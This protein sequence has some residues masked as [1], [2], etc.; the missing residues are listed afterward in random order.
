MVA[1]EDLITEEIS[2]KAL[3]QKDSFPILKY[4]DKYF[5]KSSRTTVTGLECENTV[6]CSGES[7][8]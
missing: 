7:C 3:G 5:S 6:D 8:A 1:E 4:S 2:S